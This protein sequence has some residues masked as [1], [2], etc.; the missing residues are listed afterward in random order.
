LGFILLSN[1]C[2]GGDGGGAGVPLAPIE[3]SITIVTVYNDETGSYTL[4]A[5]FKK[6]LPASPVFWVWPQVLPQ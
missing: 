4:D 1:G 5:G 6:L 3:S 2:G